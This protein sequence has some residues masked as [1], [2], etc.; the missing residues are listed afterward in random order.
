MAGKLAT[1]DEIFIVETL[2]PDNNDSFV[3]RRTTTVTIEKALRE[4][5]ND[6]ST[7]YDQIPEKYI[8]PVSDF[9]SSPLCHIIN[10]CIEKSMFPDQWKIS[11]ISLILNVENAKAPKDYRPISISPILSKVFEKI[12]LYQMNEQIDALL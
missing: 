8:K 10:N 1:T 9:L 12:M 6:C 11:R 4:L 3:F 7:G 5:R 2:P